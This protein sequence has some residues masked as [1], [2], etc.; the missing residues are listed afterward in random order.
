MPDLKFYTEHAWITSLQAAMKVEEHST[1][2]PVIRS[3]ETPDEAEKLFDPISY[4]KGTEQ[5]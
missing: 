1:T 5:T 3:A 4:N 2:V